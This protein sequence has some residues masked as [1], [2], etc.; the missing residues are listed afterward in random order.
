[1]NF[2]HMRTLMCQMVPATTATWELAFP[3]FLSKL[4][5]WSSIGIGPSLFL[6]I[7]LA[8]GL[9]VAL[10]LNRR[11]NKDIGGRERH[12]WSRRH[13]YGLAWIHGHLTHPSSNLVD[14]RMD[15]P[16]HT[17]GMRSEKRFS[18]IIRWS[19]RMRY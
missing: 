14:G 8:P 4:S 9:L 19:R 2:I 5:I 6:L 13:L 17:I 3:S 16:N 12:R 15:G 10:V 18:K 7:F 11:D 1:M